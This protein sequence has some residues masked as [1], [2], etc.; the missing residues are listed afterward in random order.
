M[1]LALLGSVVFLAIVTRLVALFQRPALP[2]SRQWQGTIVSLILPG[3][4]LLSS[5]VAILVMGHHGRMWGVPVDGMPCL[6]AKVGIGWG[7]LQGFLLGVQQWKL[8]RWL[9]TLPLLAPDELPRDVFPAGAIVH[10]LEVPH[11]TAGQTGLFQSRIVV[12]QG[13]L[14]LPTEK[15]QAVLAH[16]QAHFH[17]RDNLWELGISWLRQIGAWLPGS[18]RLWQDLLLLRECRADAYAAQ[19]IDP[20]VLAETLVLAVRSTLPESNTFSLACIGLQTA[21]DRVAYRV[22]SLLQV[23]VDPHQQ[24]ADFAFNLVTIGSIIIGLLPLG[25]IAFHHLGPFLECASSMH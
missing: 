1:H 20:L 23:E 8:R 11:I 24:D 13:L 12:S 10:Y 19:S 9:G 17:Y 3:V 5:V 25:T 16:E 6:L 4:L 18:D 22:E 7:I 15:I 21:S 2:N 14:E